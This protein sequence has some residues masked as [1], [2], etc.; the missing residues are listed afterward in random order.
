MVFS[1]LVFPYDTIYAIHD[2]TEFPASCCDKLQ[3][4]SMIQDL[5]YT[6][7]LRNSD[8]RTARTLGFLFLQSE[9]RE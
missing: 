3:K 4:S 1:H 5:Y 8:F 2:L 7:V 6:F 9:Y